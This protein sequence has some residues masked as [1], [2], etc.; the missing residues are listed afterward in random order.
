MD[1]DEESMNDGVFRYDLSTD[2]K[3][4]LFE[5][6]EILS[7]FVVGDYVF[8]ENSHNS[9][10]FSEDYVPG[11]DLSSLKVFSMKNGEK[12]TVSQ[13]YVSGCVGVLDEK[14]VF[15]SSE[16]SELIIKEYDPATGST[17]VRFKLNTSHIEKE[18]LWSGFQVTKNYTLITYE[19]YDEESEYISDST[20]LVV[21]NITGMVSDYPMDSDNVTS[22]AAYENY[23]FFLESV[24][25]EDHGDHWD[26]A[27]SIIKRINL[28]DGTIEELGVTD[29]DLYFDFFYVA[30]DE[31]IYIVVENKTYRFTAG[32]T[33]GEF[34]FSF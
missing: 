15:A 18:I 3:E 25:P 6:E 34:V 1:Y 10:G 14:L 13:N 5:D 7:M 24:D 11:S 21:D 19:E 20:F 4:V 27:Q 17:A 9:Y 23:L 33:E 30:S 2:T 31:T 32:K 22:F 29:Y 28:G 8:Y 12:I 26:D 16:E